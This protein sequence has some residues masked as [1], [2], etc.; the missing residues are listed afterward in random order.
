M[1]IKINHIIENKINDGN[2]DKLNNVKLNDAKSMKIAMDSS[3]T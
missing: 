2:Q 1:E 3:I